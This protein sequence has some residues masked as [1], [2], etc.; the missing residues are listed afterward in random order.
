MHFA[1]KNCTK[2]IYW[3]QISFKLSSEKSNISR[4]ECHFSDFSDATRNKQLIYH[5]WHIL[6]LYNDDFLLLDM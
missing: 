3:I 6:N 4:N 1:L 5:V 2:V